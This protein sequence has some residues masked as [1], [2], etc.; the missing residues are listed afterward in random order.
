MKDGGHAYFIR[1]LDSSEAYPEQRAMAAFVLAVIVDGHKRGQEACIEAG[2]LDVC[3]KHLQAST[4]N[5]AQSEPLFLQWLCLCLG[6]IWEDFTEAQIVGLQAGAAVISASLLTEPQPEVCISAIPYFILINVVSPCILFFH[7]YR[8]NNANFQVRA[9]A[10][11]A[12]GT[13][14]GVG[15]DSSG[16]G[17][18]EDCDDDEKLKAEISII[19]NLLNVVSDGSPLVRA[20]VAV[21]KGFLQSYVRNCYFGIV[22]AWSIEFESLIMHCT[23]LNY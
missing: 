21:G 6:K 7:L 14:L 11:Y 17:G 15:F 2:L 1:F 22:M 13:L 3:L 23:K 8:Q 5:D 9:S 10:V 19:R 12:L 16:D 18:D 20:E 4:P